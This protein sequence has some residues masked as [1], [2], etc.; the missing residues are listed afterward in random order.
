MKQAVGLLWLQIAREPRAL[1]WADM[2]QAFGL[3][4]RG[5]MRSVERMRKKI[6]VM[7]RAKAA[8]LMRASA[9][10]QHARQKSLKNCN[11]R[12]VVQTSATLRGAATNC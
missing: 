3:K 7:T 10:A 5:S 9:L 2:N 8:V 12:T 1:P 6:L 4:T 11:A